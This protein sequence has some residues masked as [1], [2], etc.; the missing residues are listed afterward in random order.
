MKQYE[1]T[2]RQRRLCIEM[3]RKKPW[4]SISAILKKMNDGWN[5]QYVYSL[6]R[7]K[8]IKDEINRLQNNTE[9]IPNNDNKID[10]IANQEDCERALSYMILNQTVG[11]RDIILAIR[12]LGT[13][14][15]F[16]GY[17]KSDQNINLNVTKSLKNYTDDELLAMLPDIKNGIKEKVEEN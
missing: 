14:K 15:C 13:I 5:K 16:P 4:E 6:L 8:E 10:R 17:H 12:E 2:D 7:K 3:A 9:D 11:A 1:L